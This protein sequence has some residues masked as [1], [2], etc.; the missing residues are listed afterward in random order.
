MEKF[1]FKFISTVIFMMIIIAL[2]LNYDVEAETYFELGQRV[3]NRGNEGPDVAF[4]QRK[5]K[6]LSFYS[7]EID[8]LYGDMTINAVIQFQRSQNIMV[9]GVAGPQTLGC[10]P[11]DKL[12]SR[13]DF[14]RNDIILL[15]RVIHGE[16]RG[17]SF[18]GKVAVGAVIL[19]RVNNPH[20]PDTIRGVILQKGQFSSLADGQANYYPLESSINAARAAL[21]GYDPT[22]GAC[23]FY[24]PEVATNIAWISARPVNI[25]IGNHV[26][27]R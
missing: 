1:R 6:E 2:F 16:A 7:G 23:Y 14:S 17:E 8:G 19:N 26:F 12:I 11:K 22:Y 4:L 15:A 21:V 13:M 20:F 18:K 24:N 27:A 5:L 9:D 25:E 3:L 10:L